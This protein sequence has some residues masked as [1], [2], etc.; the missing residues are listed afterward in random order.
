MVKLLIMYAVLGESVTTCFLA[1]HSDVFPSKSEVASPVAAAPGL[2]LRAQL[3]GVL[4]FAVTEK[5]MICWGSWQAWTLDSG[6]FRSCC[7]G[8]WMWCSVPVLLW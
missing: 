8:S 5:N 7:W 3:T 2:S 1:E 4:L 6:V